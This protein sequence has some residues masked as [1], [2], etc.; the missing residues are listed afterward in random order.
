M[1]QNLLADAPNFPL[2]RIVGFDALA[3]AQLL[4]I[5][6]RF[7]QLPNEQMDRIAKYIRE[8]DLSLR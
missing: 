5:Y 8:G 2:S 6:T 7:R 1:S 4:V 3:G